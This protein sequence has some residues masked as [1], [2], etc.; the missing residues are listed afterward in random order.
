M[1]RHLFSY[2][3]RVRQ[4]RRIELFPAAELMIQGRR[5]Q[6][7]RATFHIDSGAT[8]SVLP[9]SD[10]KALG[11]SLPRG[12]KTS[13]GGI[14]GELIT[15]YQHTI[16]VMFG[17]QKIMLPVVFAEHDQ[18]PRILGRDGIFNIFM[19]VFDEAHR[20]VAFVDALDDRG[21]LDGLFQDKA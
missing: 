11:M 12:K 9:A 21:L 17:T 13:I 6:G 10:A 2:G 1:T 19:I 15:G 4:D 3:I 16:T 18:V 5:K 14:T 20:R 7:I 8:I